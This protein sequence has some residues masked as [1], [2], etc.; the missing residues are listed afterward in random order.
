MELNQ[1]KST[2]LHNF[3]YCSRCFIDKDTHRFYK[4]RNGT[5]DLT[6]RLRCNPPGA[7]GEDKTKGVG[8]QFD[9]GA[10]IR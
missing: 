6:R 3:P 8:T 4:G 10:G 7:G 9:R 1:I 2:V 5:D